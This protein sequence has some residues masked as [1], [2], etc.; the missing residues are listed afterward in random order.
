VV[1]YI[2]GLPNIRKVSKLSKPI[3]H[4]FSIVSSSRDVSHWIRLGNPCP[5]EVL[6]RSE[7]QRGNLRTPKS[8]SGG[9]LASPLGKIVYEII[10]KPDMYRGTDTQYGY[11]LMDTEYLEI[12]KLEI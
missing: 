5:F 4:L 1:V 8:I 2:Y 10:Y 12:L 9:S 6:M 3:L 11:E 7:I